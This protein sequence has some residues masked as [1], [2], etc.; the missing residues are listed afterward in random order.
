MAWSGL[1]AAG[2]KV[3]RKKCKS[4]DCR[5]L[6][7]THEHYCFDCQI[8]GRAPGFKEREPRRGD[9][10]LPELYE[11]HCLM[12]GRGYERKLLKAQHAKL[13]TGCCNHCGGMML[14]ERADM[15][16]IG[17]PAGSRVGYE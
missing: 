12:C 16:S 14:V 7:E 2:P 3:G 15:G 13:R 17:S 1:A 6:A 10:E 5:K 11:I 4:D 9:I 8:E